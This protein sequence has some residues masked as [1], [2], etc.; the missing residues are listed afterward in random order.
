MIIALLAGCAGGIRLE[1]TAFRVSEAT[2]A[3]PPMVSIEPPPGVT[4]PS[5]G[6]TLSPVGTTEGGLLPPNAIPPPTGMLVFPP[7]VT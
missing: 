3:A 4:V 7:G 1:V 2:A 6:E 5:A